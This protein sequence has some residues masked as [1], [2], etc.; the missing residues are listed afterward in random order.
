MF[1]EDNYDAVLRVGEGFGF[2]VH[3]LREMGREQV[4]SLDAQMAPLAEKIG[5][6]ADWRAVVSALRDD[7]PASMDDLLRCYRDETGTRPRLRT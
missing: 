4:E 3:T 6:T 7:H 2:D 5:G 1:G